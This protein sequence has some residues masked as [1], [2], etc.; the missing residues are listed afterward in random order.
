MILQVVP[1]LSAT[2]FAAAALMS[3][4]GMRPVFTL[5]L[6]RYSGYSAPP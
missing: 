4:I 1:Y 6:S 2:A 3:C 5:R